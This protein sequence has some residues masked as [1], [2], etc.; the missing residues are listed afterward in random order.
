VFFFC[1]RHKTTV[2][3]GGKPTISDDLPAVLCGLPPGFT[4][5]I[6]LNLLYGLTNQTDRFLSVFD[7]PS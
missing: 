1:K 3:F 4:G 7:E 6:A 5:K 2:H